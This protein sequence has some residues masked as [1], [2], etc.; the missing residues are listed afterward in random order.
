MK[1]NMNN[2][3]INIY[4]IVLREVCEK[5]NGTEQYI[6]ERIKE[7]CNEKTI[8]RRGI[9]FITIITFKLFVEILQASFW[10]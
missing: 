5:F 6:T 7:L 9:G 2:A 8:S 10:A 3:K 1:P 4:K